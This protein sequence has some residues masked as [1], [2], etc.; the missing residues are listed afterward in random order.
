MYIIN[1]CLRAYY[2]TGSVLDAEETPVKERCKWSLPLLG[3]P[4]RRDDIII[5]CW[6]RLQFY[7]EQCKVL[8]GSR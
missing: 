1:N 7:K 5:K 4:A 8:W 3:S 6:M 2:V